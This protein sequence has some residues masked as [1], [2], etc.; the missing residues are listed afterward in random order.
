MYWRLEKIPAALRG[1]KLSQTWALGVI[2]SQSV[3]RLD[4]T[5]SPHPSAGFRVDGACD[6]V[7]LGLAH[8][9]RRDVVAGLGA[10]DELSLHRLVNR[11]H[12]PGHRVPAMTM[13]SSGNRSLDRRNG[14][15]TSSQNLGSHPRCLCYRDRKLAQKPVNQ[16][17]VFCGQEF[18]N[19]DWF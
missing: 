10:A 11:H 13:F 1:Q 7:A 18:R 4:C 6:G 12:L 16:L 17:D 14:Q 5:G 2:T 19:L 3:L 15:N 9:L 8:G